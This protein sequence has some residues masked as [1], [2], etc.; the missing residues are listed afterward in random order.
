MNKV[1]VS[2]VSVSVFISLSLTSAQARIVVSKV[3][4]T[5][6]YKTANQWQPLNEGMS[7]NEGT[8]ISTGVNSSVILNID[9]HTLTVNPLTMLKIYENSMT[10]TSSENRIGLRRGT[11]RAK[12]ARDKR[13]KTIFK[14]STPVATS[15]VR[16]TEEIISY[17]PTS[18]MKVYMIEGIAVGQSNNGLAS[19]L[20]GGL[21]FQQKTGGMMPQNPLDPVQA[22]AIARIYDTFLT[23][24]EK[25]LISLFGSDLVN[26]YGGFLDKLKSLMETHAL[27]AIFVRWPIE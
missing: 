21:V 22:A 12:V 10:R 20:T 4:G 3:K 23:A 2:I 27:V 19:T 14:V 18:G 5:A 6:A 16:G 24:D 9:N 7:L 1:L 15:S 8:K 13:I 17:G 25:T 26:T 11:I